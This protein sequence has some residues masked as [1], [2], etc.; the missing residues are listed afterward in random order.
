PQVVKL[1]KDLLE[2]TGVKYEEVKDIYVNGVKVGASG[3]A[4][5]IE[6]LVQVIE[7]K[8]SEALPEEAMHIA[9]EIIEQKNPKLFNRLLSEIN[10]FEIYKKVIEEYGNNPYYQTS[11]GKPDIRKLKKEAIAK[12]LVA[13][14]INKVEGNTETYKNVAKTQTWWSQILDFIKNLFIKSGFDKAAMDIISG[15]EIGTIK[16]IRGRGEVF[17]QLDE[18]SNLIDKLKETSSKIEKNENGYFIEGKRIPRVTETIKTW[19]DKMF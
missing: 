15:K 1:A 4:N 8:E 9:V 13:T 5:S 6:G 18:Q 19:A 12:Q 17:L 16:D 14:I 2:R 7:G 3:V 10:N 11:D